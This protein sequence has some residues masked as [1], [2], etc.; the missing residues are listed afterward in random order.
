MCKAPSKTLCCF[1]NLLILL[2][3]SVFMIL[4]SI[5]KYNMHFKQDFP[6]FSSCLLLC[7]L[8]FF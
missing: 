6:Y 3:S 4:I 7:L 2:N 5:G 8:A 1:N